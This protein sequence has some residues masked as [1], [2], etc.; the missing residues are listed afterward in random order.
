M[1]SNGNLCFYSLITYVFAG[2]L[3]ALTSS[4]CDISEGSIMSHY[5]KV[6][7]ISLVSSDELIDSTDI[8]PLKQIHANWVSIMPYGFLRKDNGKII[9][10]QR[11]QWKGERK[12]G[13][14]LMIELCHDQ[15]L[16]VMLKPQVWMHRGA[17]TG[18]YNP[19]NPILWLSFEASYREYILQYAEL[20][21]SLQ[22]ELFCI[23]T[24]WRSFVKERPE[25]WQTLISEVRH[26]FNGKL[27][28]AANWDEYQDT[29]FWKELDYIGVN[30]YMPLDTARIPNKDELVKSWDPIMSEMKRLSHK[31]KRSVLLTEF[32]YRSVEY[33]AHQPWR[34]HDQRNISLEA[35]AIALDALFSALWKKPDIAGGF[36]WK[37]YHNHEQ[38]GGPNNRG[39]TPQNKPAEQIVSQYYGQSY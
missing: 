32:G 28:Y 26:Q 13:I 19:N 15:G 6:N 18:D 10:N 29:P 7:G 8:K 1:F 22:V 9:F 27:V 37:W 20:A 30:A 24:E 16:K 38:R 36:L 39:Y 3:L 11:R 4:S 23:G 33:T 2:M 34:S 17:Y 35:Q 31:V 12:A 25:F 21:D 5:E 14:S